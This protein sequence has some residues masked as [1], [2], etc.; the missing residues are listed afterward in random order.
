MIYENHSNIHE[1]P[2]AQKAYDFV[3]PLGEAC[4]GASNLKASLLREY[5]CP[6]DWVYGASFEQRVAILLNDFNGY[7][8]KDKL[9]YKQYIK[10]IHSVPSICF[11]NKEKSINFIHDFPPENE[12]NLDN[13][14][15]FTKEKYDRRINRL[16][17]ILKTKNLN[18]LCVYIQLQITKISNDEIISLHNKLRKKFKANI[19]LLFIRYE[20]SFRMDEFTLENLSENLFIADL[21]NRS[22]LSFT[23]ND[24]MLSLL[25]DNINTKKLLQIKQSS[26]TNTL[27][28]YGAG[29][30]GKQI[31]KRLAY[32]NIGISG[33]IVSDGL[34]INEIT[35]FGKIYHLKELPI[36]YSEAT[37]IFGLNREN[38]NAVKEYLQKNG[39][40]FGF[41]YN[42]S[43]SF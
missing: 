37:V 26:A 6:F 9:E 12:L 17:S 1:S 10:K 22:T 15:S 28:I 25:L 11:I 2:L 39:I 27:Y 30:I 20:P 38:M 5:S 33:F 7:F 31:A 36:P 34:N 23:G 13:Y 21:N 3:F 40:K 41:E 16:L 29:G 43:S 8:E 32:R 19:D 14:Y 4:L 24:R 35:D 42:M 18:I